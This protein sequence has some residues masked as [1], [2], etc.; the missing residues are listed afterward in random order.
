MVKV[1]GVSSCFLLIAKM[2][3]QYQSATFQLS[4]TRHIPFCPQRRKIFSTSLHLVLQE[5]EE[6]QRD[7]KSDCYLTVTNASL[8]QFLFY[9]KLDL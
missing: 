9:L 8:L 6:E 2:G 4:C 5:T 1:F 7:G 3:A